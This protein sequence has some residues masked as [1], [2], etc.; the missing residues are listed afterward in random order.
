[1]TTT[2]ISKRLNEA[3]VILIQLKSK[4]R[5]SNAK[6]VDKLI[7]SLTSL[8][9]SVESS[10]LITGLEIITK[11]N[12]IISALA[13]FKASRL[14]GANAGLAQNAIS[15]LTALRVA[16]EADPTT[17]FPIPTSE[18]TPEPTPT[19]VPTP[20][21]TPTPSTTPSATLMGRIGDFTA[22]DKIEADGITDLC[23]RVTGCRIDV[24]R[25][26]IRDNAGQGAVWNWPL[27][28]TYIIA[29][30]PISDSA[31]DLYFPYWA[32]YTGYSVSLWFSDG[33]TINLLTDSV[34]S[35]PLPITYRLPPTPRIISVGQNR[36]G[37][38]PY[39][40]DY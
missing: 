3:L 14:F 15:I 16:L 32:D 33:S 13:A 25:V 20:T 34:V 6:T 28:G 2:E 7:I 37:N 18:P 17:T 5:K 8:I 23:I 4:L 11:L 27:A 30:K 1:M 9:K 39:T 31:V 36:T 24:T 19:P 21:P 22:K 40:P 29:V 12:E 38:I 10:V 35:E 26:Q